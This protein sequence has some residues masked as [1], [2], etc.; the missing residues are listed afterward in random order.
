[1]RGFAA[2]RRGTPADAIV[3]TRLIHHVQRRLNL[4][5][6]RALAR[7]GIG[8]NAFYVLI[9]IHS[10]GDEDIN[11]CDLSFLTNLS[12]ANISRLIDEL[13]SRGW[14]RRIH[15]DA[16]RRR[17]RLSLTAVGADLVERVLPTVDALY[18]SVWDGMRS[19]DVGALDRALRALADRL[20]DESAPAPGAMS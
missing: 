8:A 12:R 14:V 15:D 11:P 1:M 20:G 19:A 2:R 6:E 17:V 5:F 16:D 13:Q 3:V 10:G 7:H 9:L 4:A 18:A